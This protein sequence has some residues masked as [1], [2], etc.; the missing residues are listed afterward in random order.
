VADIVLMHEGLMRNA[1]DRAQLG[2]SV[3]DQCDVVENVADGA[4]AESKNLR[5]RPVAIEKL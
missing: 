5:A 4:L 2:V 1:M 3:A